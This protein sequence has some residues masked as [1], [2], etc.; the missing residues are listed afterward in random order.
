V[1][2]VPSYKTNDEKQRREEASEHREQDGED[3][4]AVW[5]DVG[6]AMAKEAMKLTNRIAPKRICPLGCRPK[7]RNIEVTTNI[8][9]P[10][11]TVTTPAY[12]R[13]CLIVDER[14]E[15]TSSEVAAN[16]NDKN[17][18]T[19]P[20]SIARNTLRVAGFNRLKQKSSL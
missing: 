18:R 9:T 15:Y 17:T 16:L 5:V 19:T 13:I 11:K 14:P 7:E 12:S 10:I 1:L 8:P 3:G 6:L 20:R 2:L 4:P